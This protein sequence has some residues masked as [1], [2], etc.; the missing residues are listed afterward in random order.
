MPLGLRG[1]WRGAAGMIFK[2]VSPA[3]RE[4]RREREESL[5]RRRRR[6]SLFVF[7]GE[8]YSETATMSM[9]G[10]SRAQPGDRPC[11]PLSHGRVTQPGETRRQGGRRER[12]RE[13]ERE[14]R[15]ERERERDFG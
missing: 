15:R 5:R 7:S 6:R 2:F 10:A 11:L 12:E 14:T 4:P 3:A 1:S 13:R 8:L 9:T